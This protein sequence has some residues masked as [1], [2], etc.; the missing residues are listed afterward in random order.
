[1]LSLPEVD[2]FCPAINIGVSKTREDY[3]RIL[4]SIAK[5]SEYISYAYKNVKQQKV[6]LSL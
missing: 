3:L 6:K 5:D 1:L 4:L 2:R